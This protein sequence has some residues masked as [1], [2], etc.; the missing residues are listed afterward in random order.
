MIVNKITG[1]IL[2]IPHQIGQSH[3]GLQTDECMHVIFHTVYDDRLMSLVGDDA[4]HIFKDLLAPGLM[5]EV[6]S[7]LYS[8]ND[9]NIDL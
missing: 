6:L 8:K 1:I 3:G 2:Y 4:A 9:L 5:E 7:S